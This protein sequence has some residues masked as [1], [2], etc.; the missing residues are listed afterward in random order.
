MECISLRGN[1][2]PKEPN[3]HEKSIARF[4]FRALPS[5][6]H[7]MLSFSPHHAEVVFFFA[8][9]GNTTQDDAWESADNDDDERVVKEVEAK[10]IRIGEEQGSGVF[11]C[12]CSLPTRPSNWRAHPVVRDGLAVD[13]TPAALSSSFAFSSVRALRSSLT[14][15]RSPTEIEYHEV[16]RLP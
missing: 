8:R 11:S 2:A 10:C 1:H 13:G 16:P 5:E 15:W 6:C 9:F 7:T 14:A 12:C 3:E 4:H